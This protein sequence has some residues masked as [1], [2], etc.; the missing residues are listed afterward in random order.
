MTEREMLQ[1]EEIVASFED[2]TLHTCDFSHADHLFVVWSLVKSHGTLGGL[3]RFEAGIKKV[4]AAAGVPEKYHAT[5]THALAILVGE[6][7]ARAPTASWDDFVAG[8]GGLFEWPS[9]VL[10]SIYPDGL[11]DSPEAREHFV[12]PGFG[13][14]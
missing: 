11:L 3:A 13:V 7:V 2:G 8:N 1:R 5:V 6:E 9:P 4:T 12:L 14:T 10:A